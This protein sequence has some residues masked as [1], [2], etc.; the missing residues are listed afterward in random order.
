GQSRQSRSGHRQVPRRSAQ[1]IEPALVGGEGHWHERERE[2]TVEGVGRHPEETS[3]RGGLGGE[4]RG[5]VR[6]PIEESVACPKDEP[7][8]R[9]RRRRPPEDGRFV[10]ARCEDLPECQAAAVRCRVDEGALA[11]GHGRAGQH[12]QEPESSAGGLPAARRDHAVLQRPLARGGRR[13]ERGAIV[14]SERRERSRGSFAQEPLDDGHRALGGV[15]GEKA[16][17]GALKPD[18]EKIPARRA[19]GRRGRLR[20]GA[21]RSAPAHE[22]RQEEE[23]ERDPERLDGGAA[24]HGAYAEDSG[25]EKRRHRGRDE[26]APGSCGHE[27]VERLPLELDEHAVRGEEAGAYRGAG[28]GGAP[29]ARQESERRADDGS[30]HGGDEKE[31]RRRTSALELRIET[32][33]QIACCEAR[34]RPRERQVV[35]R[36][37]LAHNPRPASLASFPMAVNES[38]RVL[39]TIHYDEGHYSL[40]L[41]AGAIGA[42]TK[43]GHFAMIQAG[44]GLRPYLRRAFSI[45]DVTTMAGVPALEFVIKIVGV[46]TAALARFAEGTPLPVLGPLGVPFPIDD[47]LH[48]DR[49]A[50]VA[51]GIGI[52]PLVL[53]ARTLA[54]RGIA[55]DLFY[56]GRNENDVLKRGDFER[57]LGPHRCRYAT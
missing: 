52:A 22:G 56:G 37:S 36:S 17:G 38:L 12:R 34:E 26:D 23:K 19:Q 33:Q 51:G 48:S 7:L 49:V 25:R 29:R 42:R 41:S 32:E 13:P 55:A 8:P 5:G 35:R 28:A 39:K 6:V 45:A 54:A 40:F 9:R 27:V 1:R 4:R 43:P 44:E 21:F 47:L 57:F 11:P 15:R 30:R 53:L 46:G 31:S 2:R 18:D 16:P 24:T 3:P 50:L 14:R 20:G 10:A